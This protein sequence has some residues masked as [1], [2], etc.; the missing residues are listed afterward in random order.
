MSRQRIRDYVE[1]WTA[2][3]SGSDADVESLTETVCE[4]LRHDPS[5]SLTPANRKELRLALGTKDASDARTF[6]DV[7]QTVLAEFLGT[8]PS[9]ET[10]HAVAETVLRVYETGWDLTASVA[11]P[12]ALVEAH[13]SLLRRDLTTE[14]ARRLV[15]AHTTRPSVERSENL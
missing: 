8:S 6:A 14:T 12:R 15:E 7:T 3:H 10:A 5:R 11:L 1:G 13:T 4:T 9:H 2:Y